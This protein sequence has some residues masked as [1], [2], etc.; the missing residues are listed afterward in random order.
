MDAL[1][2]E[3]QTN[4]HFTDYFYSLFPRPRDNRN[5]TNIL[6]NPGAKKTNII[7]NLT[8]VV[9]AVHIV[10]VVCEEIS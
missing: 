7:S 9:Q 6:I 4:C 10:S 3:L 8:L 5:F 2:D 1:D